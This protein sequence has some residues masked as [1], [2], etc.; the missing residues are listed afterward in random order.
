MAFSPDGKA[1]LFAGGN[2]AQ[3]R[4]WD[5]AE[6][7]DDDLPLLESW[8]HVNTGLTLDEQGQV[9]HLDTRSPGTSRAIG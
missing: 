9:K 7:R 6:L 2:E 5:V 4:L 8:V 1:V 3:F